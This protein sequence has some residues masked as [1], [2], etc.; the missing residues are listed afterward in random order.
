MGSGLGTQIAAIE[1][2]Q[3]TA[4]PT[5]GGSAPLMRTPAPRLPSVMLAVMVLPTTTLRAIV[6]GWLRSAVSKI[7]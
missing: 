5:T 2:R 4:Q 1:L 3:S 7:V 6:L